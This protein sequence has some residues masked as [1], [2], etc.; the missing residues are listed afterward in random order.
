MGGLLP[1][2]P[3]GT[4]ELDSVVVGGLGH[5]R[6]FVATGQ[7]REQNPARG[8]LSI[9]NAPPTTFCFQQ[10]RPTRAGAVKNRWSPPK[11]QR[12]FPVLNLFGLPAAPALYKRPLFSI[13]HI[14]PVSHER[15]V[16]KVSHPLYI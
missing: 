6:G 2:V 15:S 7:G 3:G 16:S 12:N 11:I 8:S 13:L 14:L 4:F 10:P 5:G 1:V 9:A